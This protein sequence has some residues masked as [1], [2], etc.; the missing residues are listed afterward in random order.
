[1]SVDFRIRI[2]AAVGCAPANQ[3]EP[4]H[5]DPSRVPLPLFS[6]TLSRSLDSFV[7][8]GTRTPN[9]SSMESPLVLGTKE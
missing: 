8:F 2:C 1:M 6:V 7:R 4:A 3:T 5:R 9:R